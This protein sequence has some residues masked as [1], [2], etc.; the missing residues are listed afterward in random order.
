MVSTA[1]LVAAA[2]V[3]SVAGKKPHI[4]FTLVDDLGFNDAGWRPQPQGPSDDLEEAWPVTR[5]YAQAGVTLNSYYTQPICTPTRGAFMSG[6]YPIRLGLQHAVINPGVAYGLPLDEISLADKLSAAGYRTLGVGKWHL[7]AHNQASLPTSRGFDEFY[8]YWYGWSDYWTHSSGIGGP[9]DCS[10]GTCFLD[11][12]DNLELDTTQN[13]TYATFRFSDKVDAALEKHQKQSADKP[14][15]LY[16]AMQNVHG[17]LESPSEWLSK[18]PCNSIK[19]K[20]RQIFC[21]Q[22]LMADEAF[23]KMAKKIDSLFPGDDV[24][25]I[26]SGDNGGNPRDGGN[27][28]PLRGHKSELWEGGVRNNA[29]IWSNSE[30]IIPLASKGSV[31]SNLM[32][33]TDWHATILEMAGASS[34]AGKLLDGVSHLAALQDKQVAAPRSE[35]LHN[36]DPHA[37]GK[38][39]NAAGNELEAAYRMGDWK[40]LLNVQDDTYTPLPTSDSASPAVSEAGKSR[41]SALFN[42]TADPEETTNLYDSYPDVVATIQGKITALIKEQLYPCNCGNYCTHGV[43]GCAYDSACIHA[44]AAAG[45]WAPWLSDSSPLEV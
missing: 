18:A 3:A 39:P 7:G 15:F 13:G 20:A 1:A 19:N 11:M 14:F 24:V 4:V 5:Q 6:R 22:A 26:V 33:V 31:Y 30:S 9:G 37:G 38:N 35:L 32:H 16:Y 8:G 2:S 45:G 40:L 36:I 44:A 41:V 28:M 27:N 21:A 43:A 17:P 12:H 29:F 23:G 25:H 42:I 10:A 34:N